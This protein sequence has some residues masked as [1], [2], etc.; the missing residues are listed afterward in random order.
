MF[1][2]SVQMEDY[3]GKMP[4]LTL[5]GH[6]ELFG[7]FSYKAVEGKKLFP[8]CILWDLVPNGPYLNYD[9]RFFQF[10]EEKIIS[11]K[12]E[13]FFRWFRTINYVEDYQLGAW[14]CV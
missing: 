10:G 2:L 7:H 4:T 6:T 5:D 12:K 14:Y 9:L 11:M 3:V 1:S 8:P 13:S